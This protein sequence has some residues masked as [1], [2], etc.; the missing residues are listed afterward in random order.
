VS[1]KRSFPIP[2]HH[3]ESDLGLGTI[4]LS[5]CALTMALAAYLLN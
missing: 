4:A 3:S 5:L 2:H 1:N